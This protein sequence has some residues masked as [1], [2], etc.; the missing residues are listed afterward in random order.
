MLRAGAENR[1]TGEWEGHHDSERRGRAYWRRGLNVR[2]TPDLTENVY[3][4][5]YVYLFEKFFEVLSVF[6][7]HSAKFAICTRRLFISCTPLIFDASLMK[8]ELLSRHRRATFH[9]DIVCPFCSMP[10]T[11]LRSTWHSPLSFASRAARR[12]NK[13]AARS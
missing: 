4:F 1:D 8:Y 13:A 12:A 3:L 6:L 2:L 5:T 7:V 11:L 10:P 9:K